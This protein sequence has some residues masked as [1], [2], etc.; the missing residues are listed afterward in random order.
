MKNFFFEVRRIIFEVLVARAAIDVPAV[1][2]AYIRQVNIEE[3]PARG[4][5]GLFNKKSFKKLLAEDKLL[6]TLPAEQL[7]QQLEQQAIKKLTE[8]LHKSV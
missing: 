6:N 1:L 5:D 7:Q 8:L 4:K 3:Q 2:Y